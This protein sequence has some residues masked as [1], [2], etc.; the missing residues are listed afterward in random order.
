MNRKSVFRVG[1]FL[2]FFVGFTAFYANAQGVKITK[3]DDAQSVEED[4]TVYAKDEVE[5]MPKFPGGDKALQKFLQDNIVYPK[6]ARESGIEGRVLIKFIVEKDGSLSN[7]TIVESAHPILDN[8]VLRLL[9]SMPNWT[10]GKENGKLI[11][12]YLTLP[13][14]FELS[15]GRDKTVITK[16]MYKKMKKEAKMIKKGKN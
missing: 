12:V 10:P 9:K 2:A 6:S 5:V 13:V 15:N 3:I 16:E 7:F 4:T 8:E 14:I 1:I 11:N